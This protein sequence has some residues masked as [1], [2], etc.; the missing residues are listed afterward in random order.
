MTDKE[1]KP[2]LE[3]VYRQY[4][5]EVESLSPEEKL[6]YF[7]GRWECQ[8]ATGDILDKWYKYYGVTEESSELTREQGVGAIYRSLA[9]ACEGLYED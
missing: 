5:E 3:P 9:I 2:L 7:F 8:K 6:E 1:R 4:L